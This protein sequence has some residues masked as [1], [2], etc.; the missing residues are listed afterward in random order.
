ML[1]ESCDSSPTPKKRTWLLCQVSGSQGVE[2]YCNTAAARELARCAMDVRG[3]LREN[4][5]SEIQVM[6]SARDFC[7][8]DRRRCGGG[9]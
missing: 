9:R 5:S 3:R 6:I 8:P 1:L 2:W 4:S 7:G